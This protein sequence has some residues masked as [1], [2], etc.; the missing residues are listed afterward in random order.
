MAMDTLQEKI[1]KLKNPAVVDFTVGFDQLPP[2]LLEEEDSALRAYFRFCT[3][4]LQGLKGIVP[5]VR[6]S[7]GAFAMQGA[8]G[9]SGLQTLLNQAKQQGYYVL[10]DLPEMFSPL[11][12]E[13]TAA[14]MDNWPCDGMVITPYLGSDVIRPFLEVCKNGKKDLFI[15]VRTSNKSAPELQDLL[16]GSRLVHAAAADIVNRHGQSMIGRYGYS[17]VAA[18]AGAGAPDSVRNLRNKYKNIFLL[19][20]GYDYPNGNAKNCSYAFDKLGRGAAACAGSSVTAAWCAAEVDSR[21]YI[22]AAQQA[23]E[24]M[25]KNLTRYITVL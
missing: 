20:D 16:T 17:Q 11:A 13:N 5:A 12:A 8:E 10:L 25:K 19:L 22:T 24:R 4:L 14:A 18:V 1:R 7:V 21:D 9:L 15:V 2:H 3:E 6:F 23:A